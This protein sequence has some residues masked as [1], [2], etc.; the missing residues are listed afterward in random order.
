MTIKYLFINRNIF[1][2]DDTLTWHDLSDSIDQQKRIAVWQQIHYFIHI[3][4]KTQ[5]Y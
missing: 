5:I 1:V 2:G 4:L 3:H